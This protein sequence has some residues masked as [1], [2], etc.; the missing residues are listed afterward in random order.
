LEQDT[1]APA[2]RVQIVLLARS[3]LFAKQFNV[4]FVHLNQADYCFQQRG[5]SAPRRA[6]YYARLSG[7]K[8]K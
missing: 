8:R 7:P 6:Q 4:A 3:H 5:F 1:R 2:K